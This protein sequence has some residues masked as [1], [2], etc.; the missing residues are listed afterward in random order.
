M[1]Q[2]NQR[3]YIQ[4]EQTNKSEE[5]SSQF[6]FKSDVLTGLSQ[7]RKS[8]PCK[9]L[10]DQRGSQL[11]DEICRTPEYYPTRTEIALLKEHAE[12]IAR[13]MGLGAHL[14]EFGSGSSIKVR[15][16]L[17]AATKLES[18]IP[19]DISRHHLMQA[20]SNIAKDYPKLKVWPITTDFTQPFQ[21]PN[22]ARDGCNVGFFPGSTI[23]NFTS[24]E[25]KAFLVNSAKI[26]QPGGSM[27]IGVDL[28]KDHKILNA[29]YNDKKGVTS[30]FS[31]NL[32]R[33]INREIGG[34]FDAKRFRHE[35]LYNAKMGRMEIFLVS[36]DQQSVRVNGHTFNFKSG[37]RI[38]TE[39]SHKYE[40]GEFQ[41][42]AR[43]SGFSPLKVWVDDK[44]LFS[45]HYLRA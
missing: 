10:Y 25:A 28:K 3:H 16:L 35:A 31:L 6:H 26:V 4:F 40:I 23:G 44:S 43:A 37:E 8:I 14:I 7:K 29:A 11:F 41:N 42:I 34:N 24:D 1:T 9:Y 17:D 15:I 30:S 12:E 20:A 19:V 32:L 33:R 5:D 39:N 18:Y 45:I 21:L 27:I 38:H 2:S 22:N 13:L 36:L